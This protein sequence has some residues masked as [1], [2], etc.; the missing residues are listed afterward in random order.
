M[1]QCPS[2]ALIFSFRAQLAIADIRHGGDFQSAIQR[3]MAALFADC[4]YASK[5]IYR[6]LS[7]RLF[8]YCKI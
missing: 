5:Q 3:V 8:R 1:V 2:D 7:S 6:R 4:A